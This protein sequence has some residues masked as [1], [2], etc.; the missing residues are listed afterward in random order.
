VRHLEQI[1]R[2]LAGSPSQP[3]LHAAARALLAPEMARLGWS[4]P[5]QEDAETTRL[6][7]RLVATLA[8]YGDAEVAAHARERFA[9]ALD[10]GGATR[11]HPSLRAAVLEAVGRA[12]S[13]AE[14][15]SLFAA[16]RA[17]ES[18]EERWT[19]LKALAAGRDPARAERLLAAALEG[20]LPPNVAREVPDMLAREPEHAARA[21]AFSVERWQR[22]AP[23]A[24]TGVFGERA[25][26]LPGASQSFNDAAQAQRL[27]ADQ[28]RL[29]GPTGTAAAEQ[30]AAR[31]EVR[32]AWR[33]REAG[34]LASAL[35]GWKPAAP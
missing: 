33:A 28:R 19:L 7:G 3:A 23:L 27:R 11:L 22:L 14:F 15:E 12:A 6:R 17:T 25:W 4:V 2:L 20:W 24:G 18:S 16:L 34:R 5:A 32:A 26:L 30:V 29:V 9:A 35:A 1:D 10:G 21:Y 8:R 31:I 13:A